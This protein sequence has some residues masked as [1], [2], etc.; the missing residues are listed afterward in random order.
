MMPNNTVR[1]TEEDL[2][3]LAGLF[4]EINLGGPSTT[5]NALFFTLPSVPGG[6]HSV[7]ASFETTET[8]AGPLLDFRGKWELSEK[9][10]D[11][12][13]ELYKNMETRKAQITG[14]GLAMRPKVTTERV[15]GQTAIKVLTVLR[16][17]DRTSTVKITYLFYNNDREHSVVFSCPTY[18]LKDFSPL[19]E[20]AINSFTITNIR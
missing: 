14:G 7:F 20:K 3:V 10:K 11:G 9:E 4:G 1:A 6:P 17:E 15:N 5:L 18:E 13:S 8:E 19:F 16:N 2:A 12:I